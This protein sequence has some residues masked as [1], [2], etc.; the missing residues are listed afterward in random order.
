MGKKSGAEFFEKKA[1]AESGL[2]FP[3]T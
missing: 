2:G 1:G 3:E